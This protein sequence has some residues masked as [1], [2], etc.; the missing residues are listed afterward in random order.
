MKIFPK[1]CIKP[2][3]TCHPGELV[4]P[5]YHNSPPLAFVATADE[6]QSRFLVQ[7]P[8][9][10]SKER[11]TYEPMAHDFPVLS[12]GRDFEL[13]VDH[14]APMELRPRNYFERPG[15]IHL[16]GEALHLRCGGEPNRTRGWPQNFSFETGKLANSQDLNVP[17]AIFTSWKVCLDDGAKNRLTLFHFSLPT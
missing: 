16:I 15:C 12:Y 13:C 5:S 1:A 3:S 7:L 2:F 11:V 8:A 9:D 17:T 14:L 4:R 10:Q 6:S